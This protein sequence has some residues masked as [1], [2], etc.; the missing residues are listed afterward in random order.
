MRN[1]NNMWEFI[2]VYVDDIIAAMNDPQSFFD[3]LQGPN[4]SSTMK[5]VRSP[6]YHLRGDFFWDD[7][8]TLLAE[9]WGY[10]P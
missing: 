5:G 3:E 10:P 8:G 4:V 9:L 2:I 7:N 1:L 6:M